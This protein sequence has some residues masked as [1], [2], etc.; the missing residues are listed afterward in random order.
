MTSWLRD[1]K[2]V[3]LPAGIMSMQP[4]LNDRQRCQNEMTTVFVEV[5]RNLKSVVVAKRQIVVRH[6]PFERQ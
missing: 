1:L 2:N 4:T 6:S 5:V 3:N